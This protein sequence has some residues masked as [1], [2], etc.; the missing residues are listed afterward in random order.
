MG[1]GRL[2]SK[3]R[4][5]PEL[6]HSPSLVERQRDREAGAARLLPGL[7]WDRTHTAQDARGGQ[8][9]GGPN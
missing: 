1:G 7:T 6:I 2:C 9:Q 5:F 4:I 3:R 8:R